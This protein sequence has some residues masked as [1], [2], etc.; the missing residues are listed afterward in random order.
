VER[1]L[2]TTSYALLGLLRLR[3]W[4]TYELAKQVHK[5]LGW[6]WPR[7]ERKLY[8]EPKR[9]VAAGLATATPEATGRRPRTVYRIT[10]EGRRLLRSWLGEPSAPPVLE[11]EAMVRVFFADGGS[12]ES[13]LSTLDGVERQAREM[14]SDLLGQIEASRSAD[15]EFTARRH[16]NALT[17]RFELDHAEHLAGWAAWA[18]AQVEQWSTAN[19]PGDWDW[20]TAVRPAPR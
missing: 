9:L 6:F 17:L 14:T 8:D 7:A 4:T 13:L 1:T 18:R 2:T 20:E 15:Y 3:P 11:M 5:G 16:V 12:K 19:D 10:P